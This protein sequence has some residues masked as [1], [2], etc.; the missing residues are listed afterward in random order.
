MVTLQALSPYFRIYAALDS[1]YHLIAAVLIFSWHYLSAAAVMATPHIVRGII[2]AVRYA[3]V[4]ML[5]L[6]NLLMDAYCKHHG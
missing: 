2:N 4:V 5:T 1:A 6:H 3:A